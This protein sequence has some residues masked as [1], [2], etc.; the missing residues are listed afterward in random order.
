MAKYSGMAKIDST[1]WAEQAEPTCPA[2][3]ATVAVR[4]FIPLG[5][6][7]SS[8]PLRMRYRAVSWPMVQCSRS[9]RP[10]AH[11][12]IYT[13]GRC[14]SRFARRYRLP[15]ANILDPRPRRHHFRK[16]SHEASDIASPLQERRIVRIDAPYSS[17]RLHKRYTTPAPSCFRLMWP[18]LP[19][20]SLTGAALPD[21]DDQ[22]Q[23]GTQ[24]SRDGVQSGQN[25]YSCGRWNPRIKTTGRA[26]RRSRFATL[27]WRT[28]WRRNREERRKKR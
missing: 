8:C 18:L 5:L 11:R 10:R 15:I 6:V 21:P 28:F 26:V 27:R 3:F 16:R 14:M 1:K 25:Q 20:V 23:G 4:A 13:N 9:E 12:L 7:R 2:Y 24:E 19:P 22:Q 17:E